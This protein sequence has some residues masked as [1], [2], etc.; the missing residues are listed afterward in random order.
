MSEIQYLMLS[1]TLA[2]IS[3]AAYALVFNAPR[4]ELFYCG[5][6]GAISWFFFAAFRDCLNRPFWGTVAGSAA[7]TFA[8]RFFSYR[9]ECPSTIYHVPGIFPLVPGML[10]YNTV[11]AMLDGDLLKMFGYALSV[12]KYSGAISIGTILVLILPYSVFRIGPTV[13]QIRAR[14]QAAKQ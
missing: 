6:C 8:A 3:C 11:T 14:K 12:L 7:M 13:S 10:V 1:S 9:R 2:F 5:L 4:R